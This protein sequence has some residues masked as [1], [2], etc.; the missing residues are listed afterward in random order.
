M[1]YPSSVVY[2]T[3]KT[4]SPTI[5]PYRSLAVVSASDTMPVTLEEVKH[6]CRVDSDADDTYIAAIVI[7]ATQWVEDQADTQFRSVTWEASYDSFPLWEIV[8]PRPP[9]QAV[10]ATI[11][12]RDPDGGT[13]TLTSGTDF[14]F[15]A[16]TIPAR[17]Y[18]N[19][20]SSWPAVRGDENSVVVRWT[21]GY[22]T[23]ADVPQVAK[24][25]VLLLSGHWYENREPV[26]HGQGVSSLDVPYT[27]ATLLEACKSGV[28]R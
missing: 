10:A 6:H 3:P 28:Y 17:C 27:V 16:R 13:H 26:I 5:T 23:A 25:L 2:V 1:I 19:Y 22:A 21:A 9:A 18:P 8:L 15:D 7:A 11:T 12:Y 24:H 4:P 14:Q 20:T